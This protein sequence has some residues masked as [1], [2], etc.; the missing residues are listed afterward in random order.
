[1]GD[2]EPPAYFDPAFSM[3]QDGEL[4]YRLGKTGVQLLLAKDIVCYHDH[5]RDL[6][7]ILR[8]SYG[9]GYATA[10]LIR[11]HPELAEEFGRV[12]PGSSL[13]KH[14]LFLACSLLF[15]PAFLVRSVWK[16]PS[17]KVIGAYLYYH[18][19]RGYQQGLGDLKVVHGA[20]RPGSS[21]SQ[22]ESERSGP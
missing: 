13:I 1:M 5:P 7:A 19:I 10:Q 9:A 15:I 6:G 22:P 16:R 21:V 12:L 11:K 2:T 20:G 3:R 8:R 18:R 17:R 4:G 14:G